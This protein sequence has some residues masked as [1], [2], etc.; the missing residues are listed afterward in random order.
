ME[1]DLHKDIKQKKDKPNLKLIRLAEKIEKSF[2]ELDKQT[3]DITSQ[4]QKL[5]ETPCH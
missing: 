2:I 3:R 4:D 1:R 5:F